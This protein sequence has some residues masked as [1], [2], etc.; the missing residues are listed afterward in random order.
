VDILREDLALT[1]T[2]EGCG[3]GECGACTILVDGEPRLSCLMTAAQLYDKAITTI[4]GIG[5]SDSLHPV[6]EAFVEHGAVQCGFCTPGMV[7]SAVHLLNHDPEPD[8]NR[9]RRAL[10]GNLC[11]CTGYVKIVDAVEAA[12]RDNRKGAGVGNNHGLDR[13]NLP[14]VTCSPSLPQ[15]LG[16]LWSMMRDLPEAAVYAG[17]TDLLVKIRSGS[18][19]PKRLI[20]LERIQEL[21][22]VV[23]HGNQLVILAATTFS[24]LLQE[25]A[26]T[27][28]LPILAEAIACLGSPLIRNMGTIGGNVCTASPAGDT[29]AP[30]YALNARVELASEAGV[31][32][33]PIDQFIR[34]PGQTVLKT[35]EILSAIHIEKPHP[36]AIQ[37]FEKVGR[38]NALACS[39]ASMAAIIR[40]SDAGIVIAASLAWG[41]VGPTVITCPEAANRLIGQPLS[42]DRLAEAAAIVKKA[43]CPITDIRATAD[44]RRT[45][46][47]NLLFRLCDQSICCIGRRK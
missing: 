25:P 15:S 37:H 34:G 35:G 23:D 20:C 46:A 9:I 24:Q 18:I 31:R 40:L 22:G 10:S 26:I 12:A 28:H 27:K 14:N 41:S 2:K 7:L 36:E 44:Y 3:A 21:K 5:E 33:L 32:S 4:E 6:Q 30:L 1:G 39:M 17:G 42:A 38:R 13:E 43:V 29:L 19:P 11:R 16:D 45:V 47:G 8:R